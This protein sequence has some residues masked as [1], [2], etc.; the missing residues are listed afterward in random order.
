MP[1]T[2]EKLDL[3]G[4]IL[5]TPQ[6]LADSRGFF[7]EAH[8]TSDFYLG[9]IKENF[10]QD[11]R[12]F[13]IRNVIRGIHFQK[14]PRPQGKLV[15]CLKGSIFDVA[16]DLRPDS[17]TFMMWLGVELNDI[18]NQML[19]IPP[20]F[21][22]GFSTLS[23]NALISYKCTN[24]YCHELDGGIIWNDP[25]IGVDWKIDNFIISEKDA[26]L[27]TLEEYFRFKKTL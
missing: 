13:S 25:D 8:K 16:V 4:V 22:H 1:F 21:G 3:D 23:E 26:K 24:E 15:S 2:F 14:Y 10:T 19:Y 12:S 20:G 5:V 6:V 27:P 17:E 7:L 9:G 11:N 18:N